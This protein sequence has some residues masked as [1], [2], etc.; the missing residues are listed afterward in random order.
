MSARKDYSIPCSKEEY[1][2]ANA[3]TFEKAANVILGDILHK[4]AYQHYCQLD[5]ILT[6]IVQR[7]WYLSKCSSSRLNDLQE[8]RKF[9]G[10]TKFLNRTYIMCFGHGLSE[11][12]AMWGLYGKSNPFALRVTIPGDVLENWMRRIEIRACPGHNVIE[13]KNMRSRALKEM[14]A[15]GGKDKLLEK[16]NV[17]SAVFRDMLYAS[18]ADEDK[19]DEYDIKRGNR[20][21]WRRVFY[22]LEDGDDVLD[23][24]Y[25]GFLKDAEWSYEMESRLCLCLKKEIDDDSISIAVPKDVIAAMS[26]TFSPW[27]KLSDEPHVRQLL[28]AALKGAGVD[29]DAKPKFQ[30]F[31]RS[32]LRDALNFK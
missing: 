32:V 17:Q 8:P 24:L 22:N 21:S 5:G 15:R 18:V 7:R 1:E 19:R 27:L 2:F 6:K 11:S 3:K 26:F 12:A 25:A 31:R 20:V 10:K 16:R 30:R 4:R 13:A 23:G 29:L 14:E 9:A 28:E